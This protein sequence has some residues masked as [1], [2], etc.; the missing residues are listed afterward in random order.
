MN[1]LA[2]ET[3]V[4]FKNLAE[5]LLRDQVVQKAETPLMQ[6]FQKNVTGFLQI[7]STYM[8][9]GLNEQLLQIFAHMTIDYY[10]QEPSEN[11]DSR[12]ILDLLRKLGYDEICNEYESKF[13]KFV[14]NKLLPKFEEFKNSNTNNETKQWERLL[15]SANKLK[16][17]QEYSCFYNNFNR[18]YKALLTPK[19]QLYE[20]IE[21]ELQ[22]LH[23]FYAN[24]ATFIAKGILKDPR[25]SQLN[26]T[27]KQQLTL[28]INDYIRKYE[29]NRDI[30]RLYDL[31]QI[32][33]RNVLLKYF[34]NVKIPQTQRDLLTKIFNDQGYANF[35]M[36]H[37]KR[38]NRFLE[39][40]LLM[41]FEHFK[42]SLN[43]EELKKEKPILDWFESFKRLTQYEARVAAFPKLYAMN[44]QH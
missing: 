9:Y 6:E 20:L 29:S 42:A 35:E 10:Y 30:N 7:H 8:N 40:K 23:I 4:K 36:E 16:E 32:F 38:F 28:D 43:R 39:N 44:F 15:N 27:L 25:L 2:S 13:G 21:Q 1:Q 19:E 17:C 31:L 14:L 18:F 37:E 22:G 26:N 3:C 12:Y 24:N 41:E 5:Q 33:Y 34:N 11:K